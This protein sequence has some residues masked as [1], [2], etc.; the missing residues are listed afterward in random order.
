ML[1]HTTLLIYK[2]DPI[3]YIYEKHA[4]SGRI[5]RW[6]MILTEYD[7]QYT[8]QKEIKGSV[9][10][11]HLAHQ[12]VDDYQSMQ[13]EFPDEHVLLVTDCEEPGPDEGPEPGSQ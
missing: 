3:K 10:A 12:V 5:A 2:M 4:L 13:F 7:I 9:V 6:K 8:T 1:N 11:D